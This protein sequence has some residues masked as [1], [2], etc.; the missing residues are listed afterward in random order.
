MSFLQQ[1][2]G[3]GIRICKM[4]GLFAFVLALLLAL[5]LMGGCRATSA[6]ADDTESTA[7]EIGS[8][9]DTSGEGFVI[10]DS[11]VVYVDINEEGE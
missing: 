1:Q 6:N 2:R 4:A 11:A 9:E 7:Q 10:E 3:R 5:G 8:I